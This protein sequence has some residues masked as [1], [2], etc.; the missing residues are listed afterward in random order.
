MVDRFVIE[1]G[2]DILLQGEIKILRKNI[3]NVTLIIQ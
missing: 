2:G 1:R 3:I